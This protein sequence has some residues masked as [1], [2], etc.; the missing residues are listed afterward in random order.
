MD[1]RTSKA[2]RQEL[3]S[4]A[5][6]FRK[7]L[8]YTQ[9]EPFDPV[10]ALDLFCYIYPQV[11]YEVVED[12]ELPNNVPSCCVTSVFCEYLIQIKESVYQGARIYKRGECRMD[13]VHEMAHAYLCMSGYEPLSLKEY[14]DCSLSPCE[15]MEWQAKAL[16][17]E[18]M[19]PYEATKEMSELDIVRIYGV[20]ESAAK[21]RCKKK[22]G[23]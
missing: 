17:G 10:N 19:M 3:R 1:H 16:A 20:S 4:L 2:S 5:K 6:R 11:H 22:K 8:D 13:I 9:D 12:Y 15:S 14:E 21:L 23:E 7:D 18:I